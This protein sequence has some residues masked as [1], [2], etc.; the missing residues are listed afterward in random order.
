MD[1]R[2]IVLIPSYEPTMLL[3][4]LLKRLKKENL[5]VIVVNDGS[6]DDYKDVF[7]KVG[8][9]ATLIEHDVNKGKGAAL[10]TGLS[11]IKDKYDDNYVVV[12]MDC[13]GQHSIRDAL[14]ISNYALEHPSE[15]VL[16]RRIRSSKTPFRSRLGNAI[17]RFFYRI[18]TGLDV[19]DTQTGL[20]A[21]S[22]DLIPF[23]L[24]IEGERFEYEMNV[25]LKSS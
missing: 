2:I 13:D 14:K 4:D 23:M 3:I 20:R 6:G 1:K 15:L 7:E 9:Y 12:T 22:S 18:T 19:Y 17:T 5:E 24:D 21:F 11:Y 25:L 8:G 10:K 16:G